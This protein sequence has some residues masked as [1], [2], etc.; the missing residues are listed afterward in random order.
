MP[1]S[2]DHSKRY[3]SSSSVLLGYKFIIGASI[4]VLAA[5]IFVFP[6]VMD[7]VVWIREAHTSSSR[8]TTCDTALISVVTAVPAKLLENSTS[9]V[10]TETNR[11]EKSSKN[12]SFVECDIFEGKWVKV[13]DL[14]P[15]YPPGSCPYLRKGPFACYENGRPDNQFLQWQWQWQSQQ[16]NAGC[17]NIPKPGFFNP[18]D[19]L[20]RLRDKKLVFVG[21]SLNRNM[22]MSMICM[23]WNA[24]QDK[25]R[26]VKFPK[27]TEFKIRGDLARRY[28][29]YNCSVVFVWSPYL[30]YEAN[31]TSRGSKMLLH[32]G[33][34]TLRLDLIDEL[35]AS[36]YRDADIVVFDSWHWWNVDKTN[37]GE[38]I[39]QEGDYLHP[40]LEI[41]EAYKKALTTWRR[42]IDNSIDSTRTQIV[43]RGYSISHYVDGKWNT[44][45]KCN[46]ETEP[47]MSNET[48]INPSP[49]R[50]KILRD[51]L[52]ELKSPVLYLNVSKLTYYRADAH[53]S[54]YAKNYSVQERIVALDH[55]DCSHWCLPGVPDTWNE[56][57]YASLLKAAKGSF[58]RQPFGNS[59]GTKFPCIVP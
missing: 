51:V 16:T 46:R 32:Q 14:K 23:L 37:H 20:N 5:I 4:L 26:I 34:R 2:H 25:S 17:N 13:N 52:G 6:S 8:S 18:T 50:E 57:L 43:F 45:G 27:D 53:P 30:I 39:F 24:I 15:Y 28:E 55:Q 10:V 29:D 56:L 3:G 48:Y 49:S 36:V 21:D 54:V 58:G 41:D 1:S 31:Q 19:F 40:K 38:N 35:P 44:G 12:S 9:T 42:W 11:K 7:S 47:I 33:P 59:V 22:Y